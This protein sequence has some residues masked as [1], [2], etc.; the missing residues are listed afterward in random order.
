[1][2]SQGALCPNQ[3]RF[4]NTQFGSPVCPRCG[5]LSETLYHQLWECPCNKTFPISGKIMSSV[6]ELSLPP[7]L[8]YGFGFSVPCRHPSAS[9]KGNEEGRVTTGMAFQASTQL[10]HKWRR[11]E[12]EHNLNPRLRRVGWAFA[13]CV[14]ESVLESMRGTKSGWIAGMPTIRLTS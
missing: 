14:G 13:I 1:M 5:A 12:G 6:S 9:G 11:L 3:R 7:K 10:C 2:V 8:I 4:E